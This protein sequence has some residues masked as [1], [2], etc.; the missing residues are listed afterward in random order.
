M[1]PSVEGMKV[2][3]TKMDSKRYSVAITRTHGPAL[4]PRQAPGYDAHLPHDLAHFLVEE[5]FGIRL[6]VFGQLAAGG[7]GVFQ[8]DSG[9]R[10]GRSRRTAHRIAELG[11]ADMTRSER[12]VAMCQPLWEARAGRVPG[13]PAII[14]MT[15]ATPFDVDRV[16]HRFDDVS[17]QWV[18]LAAGESITLDWPAELVFDAA[19]SAQGRR[20]QDRRDRTA[21]VG[22]SR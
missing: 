15:L 9:D 5:Q 6:G 22:A 16:I 17:A 12:L 20:S 2:T 13:R 3:F 21:R 8:P 11:R 14:D 10:S 1:P 18:A 19:G 4:V 7:E